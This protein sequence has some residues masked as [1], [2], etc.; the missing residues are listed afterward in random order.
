MN[1]SSFIQRATP[2][3]ILGVKVSQHGEEI[4]SHLWEEDCRRNVYSATKSFIA[5]AVGIAQAEGLLSI[6]EKLTDAF[7]NDL[8]AQVSEY[9]AAA[10]VRD[11]LT[12]SLGQ[13]KPFLMGGSRI[14]LQEDDWVRAAL[15]QPFTSMPGEQFQYNN[16][17]PYL[18]GILVQRRAGCTLTEYLMP[19]LFQPMGFG[20]PTWEVDPQGMNFGAGGLMLPLRDLHK[21]G[22][23]CLQEG[24][25]RG[26][27]LV[28][29]DWIHAC[30]SRQTDTHRAVDYGY[31]YLFWGGPEGSWRADG[32]YC[33]FSIVLKDKDAVISTMCECREGDA[34][35]K[36]IF[37]EIYPQL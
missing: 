7:P 37:E 13:E 6:D 3:R 35:M 10:T 19:R 26:Q 5:L 34:L 2:L 25:W 9:L 4:A 33:Q 22:L 16:V 8:P 1:L 11:L 29:A 23:L 24:R 15:A 14:H 31:G 32:K 30:L 20:L 12:M 27:Q 17:G 36:A 18:A 28:P 21:L